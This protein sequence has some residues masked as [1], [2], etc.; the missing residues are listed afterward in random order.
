[1]VLTLVGHGHSV[2][3]KH[4]NLYLMTTAYL[5]KYL[6]PELLQ[7]MN[8]RGA[9]KVIYGSDH[10][11]LNFNRTLA[12]AVALD[13]REGVLDAYLYQNA[14]NVFFGGERAKDA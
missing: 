5:P 6:P 11:Y 4:V 14:N 1:M 13:L 3:A 12:S 10:P 9:N 8:T 2:D 7:Y